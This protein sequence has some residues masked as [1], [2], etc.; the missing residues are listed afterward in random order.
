MNVSELHKS[1]LNLLRFCQSESFQKE[2]LRLQK[3]NPVPKNSAILS[4]GPTFSDQLLRVGGR[5]KSTELSL[6]CHSQIIIDRNH[7][8]AALLIKYHHEI[9][10]H[11]G[12]QQT[13]S[14]IRKRYWITSCRGLIQ[15]VLKN[16]SYCK[17]R[18]AKTTTTIYVKHTY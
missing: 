8:L 2:I 13:L 11:S 3:G 18:S 14:S 5:L 9:N 7:P 12:R 17:R 10:L 1:E 6:K 16:C 4:L 15:R